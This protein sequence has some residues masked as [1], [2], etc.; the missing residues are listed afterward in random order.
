MKLSGTNT[1]GAAEHRTPIWNGTTLQV[2]GGSAIPDD[3]RIQLSG[4][5][6]FEL[7]A[8]EAIGSLDCGAATTVKLHDKTLTVGGDNGAYTAA[9]AVTGSGAALVK[10][11]TGTQTLSG[12]NITY[13]GTTTVN[14]GT[15]KLADTAA[16]G[17]DIALNDGTLELS[18]T[19][20]WAFGQT[21]RG[22][23]GLGNLVKSG[24]GRVILS[25]T[26]TFTGN[27]TVSA[28]ILQLASP[29][30]LSVGTVTLPGPNST[31][32]QLDLN[33][34]TIG[35]AVA[36]GFGACGGAPAAPGC[37]VNSDAGNTAALNGPLALGGNNYFGGAGN[38]VVNGLVSG[39]VTNGVYALLKEGA[40]TW[41]LAN[42]ANTYDGFT[43]IQSGTLAV[44]K[45]GNLN[46]PS[47]LGQPT[48]AAA[49]YLKFW[50]TGGTLKYIG[51]EASACDRTIALGAQNA[52]I[53]ALDA[54]GASAS[55]TLT[56]TGAANAVS[57]GTRTLI[58]TGSNAGVNAYAGNIDNGS[59]G[60]ALT[61]R[62]ST[63]WALAGAN[64][65]TGATTV[66][67]GTLLLRNGALTAQ[68]TAVTL[69]GGTLE[70]A[71]G[72]VN[73][74]ATLV[75]T[76]NSTLAVGEGAALSFQNSAALAGNWSGTLTIVGTLIDGVTLRVGTDASGLD[77]SQ[78]ACLR[79]G[80]GQVRITAAGYVVKG[81]AGTVLIVR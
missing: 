12:T 46:E 44:T 24:A 51:A 42:P 43:Y 19:G 29:A 59:G 27:T 3:N 25:G 37:L 63:T 52:V 48:T 21:I 30:A 10:T 7:L 49:N 66:E 39:G 76:G 50:L 36:T 5:A 61:K 34:Q 9:G 72:A 65:Y 23:G 18:C 69:A 67:E 35:N 53:G 60:V 79:N 15:L 68:R 26:N 1:F 13:T 75:T 62:G 80:G 11:G 22:G 2:E 81:S 28:G 6:T 32:S 73:D 74:L 78:L 58:L 45:L 4:T 56:W 77:S 14:A 41:T 57:A 54:S 40:G 71:A 20:A 47:S 16:F 17:T 70:N 55:A 64:T 8:N 31:S 33:G 38:V